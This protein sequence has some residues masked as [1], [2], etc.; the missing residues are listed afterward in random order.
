MG[1]KK[2]H[3]HVQHVPTWERER[4]ET[5]ADLL[6]LHVQCVPAQKTE[7]AVECFCWTYHEPQKSLCDK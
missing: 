7:S 3:P 4:K 5:F 1:V 2:K 6:E